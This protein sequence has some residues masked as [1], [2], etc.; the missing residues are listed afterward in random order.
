MYKTEK[1]NRDV[2]PDNNGAGY[3]RPTWV[4]CSRAHFALAQ[5]VSRTEAMTTPS[6]FVGWVGLFLRRFL[7]FFLYILETRH[8]VFPCF[9]HRNMS[10]NCFS[11]ARLVGPITFFFLFPVRFFPTINEWSEPAFHF[12]TGKAVE[13]EIKGCDIH[14]F[15]LG[16]VQNDNLWSGQHR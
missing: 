5:L 6:L 2:I 14:F 12:S 4:C 8:R 1:Y 13:C 3:S 7:C 11:H 10:V 15:D 9:G 16:M